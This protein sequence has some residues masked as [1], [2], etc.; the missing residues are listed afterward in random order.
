M[1]ML[2]VAPV[3]AAIPSLVDEVSGI[4]GASAASGPS[5]ASFGEAFEKALVNSVNTVKHGEKAMLEGLQGRLGN[6][7]V[8]NA[9][10]AAENTLQTVVAI[11]DRAVNA[12]Q[13]VMRM[14][15]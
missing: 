7:E 10:L 13:E 2:S 12:Y 4:S 11:R 14:P 15:I 8:V 6:Q 5:K 3:G 1:S 9:V